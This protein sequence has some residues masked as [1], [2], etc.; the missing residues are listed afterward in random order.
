[1]NFSIRALLGCIAFVA[2]MSAAIKFGGATSSCTVVAIG[3]FAL[4]MAITLCVTRGRRQAFSIGFL[5]PF[6]VYFAIHYFST[7][8]ETNIHDSN[9]PTTQLIKLMHGHVSTLD[10]YHRKTRERI[11]E[12]DPSSS[13][14]PRNLVGFEFVPDKRDFAMLA[15]SIFA[16]L[17]G[18]VGG[19]FALHA[20]GT[21]HGG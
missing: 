7:R 4:A 8:D 10:Y 19:T 5:I 18:I 1:M 12:Y 11:E 15:H 2:M 20:Y 6:T 9:L 21:Q 14:I 3:A 13:A 17:S 16:L